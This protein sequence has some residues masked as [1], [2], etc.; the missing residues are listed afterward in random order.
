MG[1]YW[2][3][4]WLHDCC[5]TNGDDSEVQ[6]LFLGGGGGVCWLSIIMKMTNTCIY[7]E[8]ASRTRIFWTRSWSWSCGC[9]A[10]SARAALVRTRSWVCRPRAHRAKRPWLHGWDS[11]ELRRKNQ[12]TKNKSQKVNFF[13]LFLLLLKSI[14]QLVHW[15]DCLCNV[16]P[17]KHHQGVVY[18]EFLGWKICGLIIMIRGVW[19]RSAVSC[20][21]RVA[22]DKSARI[23][24]TVQYA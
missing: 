6:T 18:G 3:P 15:L 7:S 12:E 4:T 10:N 24:T 5:R 20:F 23:W 16:Y 21:V 9:V 2:T 17:Y 14:V 19:G 13:I 22:D 11:W 1:A 8:A